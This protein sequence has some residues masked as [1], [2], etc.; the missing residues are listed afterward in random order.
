MVSTN[1]S[2]FFLTE[3]KLVKQLPLLT[4]SRTLQ[5]AKPRTFLGVKAIYVGA[6]SEL[7]TTPISIKPSDFAKVT[8]NV[9][10][11]NSISPQ[12]IN[13]ILTNKADGSQLTA[14]VSETGKAEI[15]YLP[16]GEYFIA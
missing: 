5:H 8:F 11:N 1:T 15:A 10:T 4:Y 3:Q 16:V 7:V 13:V 6:E 2:R 14:K 12:G 9:T